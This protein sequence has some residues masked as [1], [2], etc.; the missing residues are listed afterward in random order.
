MIDWRDSI[1]QAFSAAIMELQISAVD[2]MDFASLTNAQLFDANSHDEGTLRTRKEW[3][4]LLAPVPLIP[5]YRQWNVL[6]HDARS[7]AFHAIEA[8]DCIS[9]MIET[10]NAKR[11]IP[12][13]K[14]ILIAV[15]DEIVAQ[16]DDP[17]RRLCRPAFG[18]KFSQLILSAPEFAD[19]LMNITSGRQP[20]ADDMLAALES[21]IRQ[22]G[23]DGRSA[24]KTR[25][26]AYQLLREHFTWL[27]GR[28]PSWTNALGVPEGDFVDFARDVYRAAGIKDITHLM[29]R[30]ARA[31]RRPRLK[32]ISKSPPA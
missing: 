7:I 17:I 29:L 6:Q 12:K 23:I 13:P 3:R 26:D 10:A 22:R 25:S 18:G 15:R 5:R 24:D 16:L 4:Q 9:L 27:T 20:N 30:P 31:S 28:T 1:A 2:A 8:H 19:A 14:S 21:A 11:A 32:A